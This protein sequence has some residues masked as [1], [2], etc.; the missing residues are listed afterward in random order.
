[1]TLLSI[2]IP[3]YNEEKNIRELLEKSKRLIQENIEIIIVN[4]GSTDN[5]VFVLNKLIISSDFLK[6]VH[7]QKN[8]GY[9]FGIYSG[10]K[11]AKG[12]YIGWT[13]A[14]LQTDLDDIIKVL[15]FL[16]DDKVF[17]K[18]IRKGRNIKDRFF[19]IGMSI[20][21]SILLGEFL[22]DINAQPNIFKRDLFLKY[23]KPP[24]DFSFDLYYYFYAV[25]EKY[26]IIRINVIFHSRKFGV[27]S[28]NN[29]FRNK[30]KFIIRTLRY[31]Y[32][33]KKNLSAF[34]AIKNNLLKKN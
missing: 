24:K 16:N 12:K 19:T 11:L 27:S 22:W 3:C 26:K 13:H 21:E 34:T 20:F 18:G 15:N 30:L 8:Q 6:V 17:I 10:L 32:Q 5:T 14:D 1:M 31:S 25:K 2:V 33:L 29:S 4:N 23:N 7:I 28:W 9:G